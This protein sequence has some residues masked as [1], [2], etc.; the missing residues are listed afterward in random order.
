MATDRQLEV[1][2]I[3]VDLYIK[4]GKE[5]SSNQVL[6]FDKSVNL[7]SATIRN[8]MRALEKEGFL[9]KLD[10]SSLRTS[11]RIPTPKGYEYYLTHIKSNPNT[12]MSIKSQ[13]DEVF[14]KRSDDI[15]ETF[16]KALKI[17]NDSTG[18]LTLRKSELKNEKLKDLKVYNI[19]SNKALVIIITYSEE[20][21]NRTID[22]EETPFNDFKTLIGIFGSRL[23]DIPLVDLVKTSISLKEI[24]ELNIKGMENKFQ[25]II[26]FMFSNLVETKFDYS[27]MNNLVDSKHSETQEQIKNIFEMIENNSIWSL[28]KDK[29]PI[30]TTF[31]DITVDVESINGVSMVNKKIDLKGKSNKITIVG[32]KYQDYEKLFTMLDYL[33][34]K[35]KK[36]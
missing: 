29:V 20:V 18:T 1:L 2:N 6:E 26:N 14:K 21:I 22:L 13:L 10:A 17:I 23:K 12:L 4:S 25:T 19:E 5:V 8:E 9:Y 7:S 3:I 24:I 36:E 31:N 32:S 27:G 34:K 11:G 33:E 15:N 35:I 30:E 28:I 16:K